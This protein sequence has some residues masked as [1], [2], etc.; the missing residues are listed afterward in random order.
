MNE[1]SPAILTDYL[2]Q[3]IRRNQNSEFLQHLLTTAIVLEQELDK[4]RRGE[5][6]YSRAAREAQG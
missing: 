2:N 3:T 4:K 6:P 1:R 5:P